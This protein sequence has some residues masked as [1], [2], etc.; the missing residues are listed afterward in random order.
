MLSVRYL[1]AGVRGRCLAA[2]W[3]RAL[4]EW[5]SESFVPA[6]LALLAGSAE[7][8]SVFMRCVSP[9]GYKDPVASAGVLV[10]YRAGFG[11]FAPGPLALLARRPRPLAG[12][13]RVRPGSGRCQ[14][15]PRAVPAAR[16]LW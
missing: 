13:E 12:P 7:E 3:Q 9:A 1:C 10:L 16:L 5:I 14:N 4:C 15:A 8:S 11:P 2:T 6:R